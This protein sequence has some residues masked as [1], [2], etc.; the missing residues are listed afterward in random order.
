MVLCRETKA[1]GARRDQVTLATQTVY[2]VL[3]DAIDYAG[4]ISPSRRPRVVA[5]VWPEDETDIYA[6]EEGNEYLYLGETSRKDEGDV[7]WLLDE[8]DKRVGMTKTAFE[9]K[10]RRK[11]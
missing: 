10:L 1:E 6:D 11:E 4:G 2:T 8:D 9:R 5:F 3:D 7:V